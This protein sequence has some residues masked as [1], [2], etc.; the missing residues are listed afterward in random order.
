MKNIF[1]YTTVLGK[2]G[3][4]EE[5]SKITNLIF[6]NE[7][8]KEQVS[9]K[10]TEVLVLAIRQLKEYFNG[11]REYFELPLNPVGT[12]FQ[13]KNWSALKEIP[14]GQT[15]SYGQVA[16]T[17]GCINGARAVGLAN[18]RNPIPIFIPCH[19]V[20]GAN[21]KLIGYRGGIDKKIE[22]LKIE[23]IKINRNKESDYEK[24]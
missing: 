10:E 17:I 5:N 21:G 23:G 7:E 14:Y 8:L 22:L 9:V 2:I 6:E 16:K 24:K 11:Q 18:N 20:I 3:I 1:Y 13:K 4:A 12:N 15:V 19:R